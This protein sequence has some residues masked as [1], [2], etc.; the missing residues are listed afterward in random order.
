MATINAPATHTQ[1]EGYLG[2]PFTFFG[3]MVD[4]ALAETFDPVAAQVVEF[5]GDFSGTGTDTARLRYYDGIGAATRMTAMSGETDAGSASGFTAAYDTLTFGRYHWAFEES[6]QRAGLADDPVGLE[7]IAG[8]VAES[9]TSTLRYLI[10]QTGAAFSTNAAD[11]TAKLDVD[12]MI[13][14][15]N[16][17]IQTEGFRGRLIS[18][19][20]PVP[21]THF[22]ASL[23][24][25]TALKFPEQFAADQRL[26]ESAGFQGSWLGIDIFTSTDV[27][28]NTDYYGFAYAPGAVGYGVMGT[29]NLGDLSDANAVV[30][31]N[32]GL[33]ITRQT[34]GNQALKRIDA[35]AYMGV[36]ARSTSVAPQWLLRSNAT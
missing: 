12:D 27:V 5:L 19:L 2:K 6:F 13:N 23:R 26:R 33:V 29:G 17:A 20:H 15:R 14:L 3:D 31:P 25:E 21:F 35:N 34:T 16:L 22:L 4:Q 1:T 11:D 10:C 9:V 30:V 28:L 36:A 7:Q 24:N 32:R 8:R 18:W